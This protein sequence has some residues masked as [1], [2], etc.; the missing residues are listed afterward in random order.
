MYCTKFIKDK[1]VNTESFIN[2]AN[3]G[4]SS[5]KI[6]VERIFPW[7]FPKWRPLIKKGQEIL[8]GAE[9]PFLLPGSYFAD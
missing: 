9:W 4:H 8:W 3:H 6:I 5:A 2:Q 1:C 7:K